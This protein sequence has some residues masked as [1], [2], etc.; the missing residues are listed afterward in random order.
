M[1]RLSPKIHMDVV[2]ASTETPLQTAS[3]RHR[4]LDPL[5]AEYACGSPWNPAASTVEAGAFL[6]V[7]V[8]ARDVFGNAHTAAGLLFQL[9]ATGASYAETHAVATQVRIR[10]RPLT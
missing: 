4:S 10:P 8:T 5:A 3:L 2:D 1:K 9:N 7:R 6:A